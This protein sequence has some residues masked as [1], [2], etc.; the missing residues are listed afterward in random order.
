MDLRR[1]GTLRVGLEGWDEGDWDR[2]FSTP[3]PPH[4]LQ[5]IL[6]I[7]VLSPNDADWH[8][9]R[10]RWSWCLWKR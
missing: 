7:L 3:S 10:P 9:A 5:L 8:Q 1:E 4:R 2:S 6:K